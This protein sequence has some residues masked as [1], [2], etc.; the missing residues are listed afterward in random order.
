MSGTM[1]CP[2][3]G[4]EHSRWEHDQWRHGDKFV[5]G[6]KGCGKEFNVS[7]I[8]DPE[9]VSTKKELPKTSHQAQILNEFPRT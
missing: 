3:C 2:Y 8:W 6:C 4:C 5:F 7:V 9:F 1:D